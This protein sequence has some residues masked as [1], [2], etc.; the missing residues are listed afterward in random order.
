MKKLVLLAALLLW[1]NFILFSQ[2]FTEIIHFESDIYRLTNLQKQQIDEFV[3]T[4]P[5]EVEKI[6]VK[7]HTDNNGDSIYNYKLSENR[8]EAVENELKRV[9]DNKEIKTYPLGLTNPL[10][11]NMDEMERQQN[12]RVEI[13]ATCKKPKQGKA[14]KL[15]ASDTAVVKHP[16]WEIYDKLKPVTQTFDI[17]PNTDNMITSAYGNKFFLPANS[18]NIPDYDGLSKVFV[19][20]VEANTMS[21]MI[22][23]NLTASAHGEPLESYGMWN[24][25]VKY[26]GRPVNLKKNYEYLTI[27]KDDNINANAKMFTGNNINVN[28]QMDWSVIAGSRIPW[29]YGFSGEGCKLFFCRIAIFFGINIGASNGNTAL[30][31]SNNALYNNYV[32]KYGKENLRSIDKMIKEKNDLVNNVFTV[33]SFGWINCD[34]FLELP[35]EQLATVNIKYEPDI[36]V[37]AKM[38]FTSIKSIMPA[39][40]NGN[41]YEFVNIPIGEEVTVFFLRNAG[42]GK[43]QAS[44][45][46]IKVT[47]G[48]KVEPHFQDYSLDEIKEMLLAFR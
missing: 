5:G 45:E 35:P 37:D 13:L 36:S 1:G 14:G 31:T 39:N 7:G 47:K 15:L 30:R 16:Y 42:E 41:D 48:C 18:L 29:Y 2:N 17:N 24:L 20:L 34:R 12:R 9:V 22:S 44:Q 43:Y 10:N 6:E 21:E 23:L 38:I 27:M 28:H 19:E 4:L 8:C 32:K 26:Y 25:K 46:K 11:A 3:K 33:P 40:V